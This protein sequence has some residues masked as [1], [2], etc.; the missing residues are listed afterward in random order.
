MSY[1]SSNVLFKRKINWINS[2][3]HLEYFFSYLILVTI[4]TV[5]VVVESFPY[6]SVVSHFE[7]SKMGTVKVALVIVL[8]LISSVILT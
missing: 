8:E 2:I 1:Q 3:S 6:V 4:P 7:M 5:I